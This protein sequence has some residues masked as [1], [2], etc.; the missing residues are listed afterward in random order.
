MEISHP[1]VSVVVIT[2]NSAKYVLA[3]LESIKAQTYQNIEL[4]VSDDCSNDDTVE[5]CRSWMVENC[6]R[7][8]RT[9]LITTEKNKGIP[10]NCNRGVTASQGLWIKI[11]AGDDLL[12]PNCISHNVL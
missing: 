5:I 1:L 7:F 10:A 4:I 11:I 8:I 2:Y 6:E 12:L 3:T 9:E